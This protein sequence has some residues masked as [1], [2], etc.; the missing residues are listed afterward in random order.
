MIGPVSGK[1]LVLVV[2]GLMTGLLLAALDGTL[3]STAMPTII[4][5]LGGWRIYAWTFSAFMLAQTAALPIFGRLSDLYGQ[6]RLFLAGLTLFILGSSLCGLAA[7]MEQLIAFRA[8]Q[9]IGAGAIFPIAIATVGL[10]FP[11]ERRARM[12]GVFSGVF[13][14]ASVVGPS[15]G[16]FIVEHWSWRWAF[17]VN[18]PV[19]LLSAALVW[20][21]LP[22]PPPG[23]RRPHVDYLGAATL[24]AAVV[25]LMFAF[26]QNGDRIDWSAPRFLG[27]LA[28][29]AVSLAAFLAVERRT[30]EPIL[31]LHLFENRVIAAASGVALLH[32]TAMFGAI[33]F[34]PFFVQGAIGGSAGAARDALMPMMLSVVVGT[35]LSGRLYFRAGPRALLTAAMG[36]AAAGFW[37]LQR[38]SPATTP[39]QAAFDMAVTGLGIGLGMVALILTIQFSVSRQE[40]G[41]ATS[42]AQFFRNLGGV[43]GVSIM[44]SWQA[45]ILGAQL[46]DLLASPL[47]ATA[48]VAATLQDARG[49]GQVLLNPQAADRIPPPLLSA[50][51][52]VLADSLHPVFLAGMVLCLLALPAAQALRMPPRHRAHAAGGG[53]G[54]AA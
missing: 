32:G 52:T 39:G 26:L 41:V 5:D 35:T 22:N 21:N 45:G 42:M 50:L 25:A 8:L 2:A 33:S 20:L 14:I 11:P 28:V 36:V 18:L 46:R 10:L 13:G 1:R 24:T 15:V 12:Q 47:F 54:A 49:L 30:P 48:K 4:A 53:D 7:S 16:A 6:R 51:R 37:L 19:G 27:L 38:M 43:L 34:I 44:G 40:M 17:Y 3:V 23:G 9:G 29:A 31:P